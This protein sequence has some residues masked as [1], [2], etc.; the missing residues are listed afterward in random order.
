MKILFFTHKFY[1][2]IGGIEV[3]SEIL[4]ES[5]HNEGHEVILVTWTKETGYK[6]FPYKVIRKPNFIQLFKLHLWAKV[7]FENNPC[8]RLSWPG[9]FIRKP[10]VIA[11]RTWIARSNG[12]LVWKDKFKLL[13]LKRAKG[14]ITVSNGVRDRYWPT[15]TVIGNPYRYK[16][17]RI[18]PN[19][20]RNKDFVFLGRLVSDKGVDLAINAFSSLL[21]TSDYNS[22]NGTFTIV[23]D[24]PQLES[25]EE[26]TK[27][28]G[29]Q[30]RIIFT[31]AL[32]GEELV[33]C[34]NSHR[35]LIVPSLWAEPFGNVALEGMACGCLPIVSDG[36]G[37]PDAV[38]KAGLTFKSGSEEAL[39][40]T[41]KNVLN[42]SSLEDELRR[43]A[44]IHLRNHQPSKVSKNYLKVIERSTI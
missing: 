7:I 41:I 33:A 38:G 14:I 29:L 15:A 23:G 36:G 32:K 25:L 31:G 12:E 22:L 24:G 1:P 10:S 11:L 18:L 39:V 20:V 9:V 37:L 5:F 28:L 13:W 43:N 35:Y 2:E 6:K 40:C 21:K 19:I 30:D 26:L 44:I 17:F 8:L 34:L 3:N 16:L 42:D 4:A 27:N